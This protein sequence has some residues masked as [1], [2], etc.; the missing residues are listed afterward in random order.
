MVQKG[1]L[2]PIRQVAPTRSHL[3]LGAEVEV[4]RYPKLGDR[5]FYQ[6]KYADIQEKRDRTGKAFLLITRET[7]YWNQNNET[8]CIV[9]TLGGER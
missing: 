3:H 4:Y 5:I 8:I 9:R 1:Q 7:R 6:S 2:T